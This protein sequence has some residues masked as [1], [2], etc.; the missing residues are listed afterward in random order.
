MCDSVYK[1]TKKI[2]NQSTFVANN[3][4]IVGGGDGVLPAGPPLAAGNTLDRYGRSSTPR[5]RQEGVPVPR[6]GLPYVVVFLGVVEKKT[7]HT[8]TFF[9]STLNK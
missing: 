6:S 2:I 1:Y 4:N 5:P 7:P 3:R 9:F 8:S